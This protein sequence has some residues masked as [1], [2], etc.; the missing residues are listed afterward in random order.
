MFFPQQLIMNFRHPWNDVS[1][2]KQ[3]GAPSVENSQT[4][5]KKAFPLAE[6]G[7]NRF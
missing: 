5:I 1:L 3:S 4:G 2:S 6:K 7:F